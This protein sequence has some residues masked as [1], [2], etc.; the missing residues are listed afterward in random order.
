M[1]HPVTSRQQYKAVYYVYAAQQVN[2]AIASLVK[3]QSV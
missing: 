2:M 3:S 1:K